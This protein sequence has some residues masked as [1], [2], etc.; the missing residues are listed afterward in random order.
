M[1]D[2]DRLDDSECVANFRFNK[3]DIYNLKDKLQIPEDVI[4]YNRTRVDGIEAFCV[5]LNRFAYPIRYGTMIPLF[6]RS[7]PELSII[8]YKILNHIHNNFSRLFSGFNHPWMTPNSLEEY[9]NIVHNKGAAL[10]FCWGFIDGTVRPVCRPTRNQR[11]L[12]NGHKRVHAINFQSVVQPNGLIVNL[13]GPI[14]GRRH[15]AAMLAESGLLAQLQQHSRAPNGRV[16]CIYGDPA[17]PLRQE[18]QSPFRRP[19]LTPQ[20]EEFNRSMSKV[21]ISVEWEFKEIITYFKFIDF[22]KNLKVHSVQLVK[23]ILLV[24]FYQTVD[25]V[26]MEIKFL[27]FSIV[28]Q[29]TLTHI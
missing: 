13:F 3:R 19:G 9:A 29:L 14:E 8:T 15:D 20:Q 23:C 24:V 17:Y 7:V 6:G 10:D 12:Y 16:L 5:F 11:I 22:K 26:C 18:L 2:L 1:L 28:I 27:N 25:H 4:C 21:R